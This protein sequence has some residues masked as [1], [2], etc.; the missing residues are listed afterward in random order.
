MEETSKKNSASSRP[1]ERSAKSNRFYWVLI[2][3][4]VAAS[5]VTNYYFREI[6]WSLR[7]TLGIIIACVIIFL[8]ALTT[9]GKKIWCFSKE[10]RTELRKVVW[11]TRDETVKIT[12]IVAVL[13]FVAAII[14]WALDS[15]LLWVIKLLTN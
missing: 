6:A 5:S 4:I 2:A 12:A 9:Q 14:L 15:L 3:I 13:V 8:A 7:F 11:P 10:A 1:H